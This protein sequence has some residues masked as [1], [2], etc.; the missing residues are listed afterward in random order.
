M[1]GAENV[2][3]DEE[4]HAISTFLERT[5]PSAAVQIEGDAGIGKTT[6]WRW[7]IE[8]AAARGWQVLTAA[9]AASEARLAFAAIGD[10]LGGAVDA[11]I[12]QLPPPQKRALDAALLLQEVRGRPP[13]ERAIAVAVLGALRALARERWL[14]VAVD[15]V[16]WL[17]R[18]SADVLSFVVRRLGDDPVAVLV[19]E[20]K[21]EASSVPL[22]L[23]RAFGE[24]LRRVRPRPLSLGATHRL[25]RTRLG[26]TLS[27]PAMRRLHELSGGNALYALE[28]ARAFERGS[29][30]LTPGEPLPET[31]Q[32]LVGRRVAE[33]PGATQAAL[34]EAAALSR[35][36]LAL[37]DER[38]ITPAIE[39]RVVQIVEGG[40]Q[41]THPLFRSASYSRLSEEQRRVL[42]RRLAEAVGDV[43]ER[44]RHLALATEEPDE[45]IAR[46]VEEGAGAAFR[47]GAPIAAAELAEQARRLTP[48]DAR[49]DATRR[50]LDEAEYRFEAGDVARAEG[51][52]EGAIESVAPGP[53][54]A[55]LLSRLARV[56]HFAEDAGGGV[57]LLREA[58]AEA[59]DDPALRAEIEE[60]LAWGLLVMRRDLAGAAEH[61]RSAVRFAERLGDRAALA[62]ALAVQ[63]LTEFALGRDPSS[64]MQRALDLEEWTLHLRVL[65]HPSFANGYL[66]NCEDRL[67]RA[68]E[69][70]LELRRRATEH[71]DE[72]ALATILNHL[73]LVEFLAGKWDEANRNAE[74]GYSL[75]L[76]SGQEPTQASILGKRALLEAVRGA[77]EDARAT[78]R[79]SLEIAA[80][81]FD[82]SS[83]EPALAR[84]GQ[85]AIGALGLVE[86]SLGRPEEAHH[87]LG[88]LTAALL[89]AGIEDPGELRCLPDDV[90][91][92]VSLGCLE[93]AEAMLTPFEGTA[94][95]RDRPTALAV[96]G[97]CRGLLLASRGHL[98]KALSALEG[99]LEQHERRPIPF[100]QGRTLLALGQVLRRAKRR[101]DARVSLERALAV[102]EELGASVWAENARGELARI[103]GRAPS[104]GDLTVS[105]R[106]LA[107]LVAE[108]Y[109]NKEAAA[110]LFV[111]PKTVETK[112]YRIYAK[113][114]IHSRTELARRLVGPKL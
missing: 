9:P 106:R 17:D 54:R 113:L 41:F 61:A 27:R 39:A 22:G 42:H 20:R 110:A 36:T 70:F 19:A 46:M 15:D 37:V 86:L 23:G 85:T 105:E 57:D 35:P 90:E 91:A 104:A 100:E 59:G 30:A 28:L 1:H 88:P 38:A 14:L 24:R 33:L 83:P 32:E 111:T 48:A 94:R 75:A 68:R 79:R 21:E 40:V 55:R 81:E 50:A 6:L 80:P 102:F 49:E 72:S 77:V 101:R 8:Q 63:A 64:A 76:E 43:E 108:G 103:S 45:T 34:A 25:L 67:D 65:R 66:L 92:L 89:A 13:D 62:E 114:G 51:V 44:A 78:A 58:L 12:S 26:L 73:T 107:E 16:Q 53:T 95:R 93:E 84:A 3:R 60:G 7:G 11:V 31:L 4:L 2:G 52:L 56:R 97:R 71:G 18:P 5:A 82:P 98:A 10:L 29:I 47:R 96:A 74:E 99:A 87:Y 69:T 109:S 112:L